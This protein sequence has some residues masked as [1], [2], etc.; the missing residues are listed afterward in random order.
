MR[1]N[2]VSSLQQLNSKA[3][4]SQ[5]NHNLRNMDEVFSVVHEDV[6]HV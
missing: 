1:T 6:L 4:I 5:L 2:I 3:F